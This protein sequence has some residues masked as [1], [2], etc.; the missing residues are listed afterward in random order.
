MTARTALVV[1]A[2]LVVA[3]VLTV[4]IGQVMSPVEADMLRRPART[5]G[6]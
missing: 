6:R 4:A 1:F 2:R 5:A 3:A